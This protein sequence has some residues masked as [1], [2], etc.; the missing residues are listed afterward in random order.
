[1]K[2]FENIKLYYPERGIRFYQDKK[3]PFL[4]I[5]FSENS[6][7]LDDYHSL[8]MRRVD[9]RYVIV[10]I[11]KVPYSR[12]TPSEIKRYKDLKLIPLQ[13]NMKPPSGQNIIFDISGYLHMIDEKF[14]PKT[15]RQRAGMLIK[16]II[17]KSFM[18][19]PDNYR[20]VLLY[21]VDTGKPFNSF[22]DRKGYT[23]I[24]D[25][26][27]N[28]YLPYNNLI[29]CSIFNNNPFY[30][31]LVKDNNYNLQRT[32][33]YVRDIKKVPEG[34]DLEKEIKTVGDEIVKDVD[35]EKGK[36]NVKD[37]LSD[38]IEL[39]PEEMEDFKKLD[40]KDKKRFIIK[41]VLYKVSGNLKKS[42]EMA[43]KIPEKS[44]NSAL[45]VIEDKY[46][47][48]IIPKQ[49][50]KNLSRDN[51]TSSLPIGKMVQEKTPEHLFVKRKLDFD[52][53]LKKDLIE[54]F[55]LLEKKEIPLFLE[56]LEIRDKKVSFGEIEKTDRSEIIAILKDEN[57]KKHRVKMD[58][59]KIDL[60]TGTFFLNGRKNC[61][62]NQIVLCPISFPKPHDSKFHSSYSSFHVYS[63]KLKNY[64]FLEIYIGSFRIPL[65][66]F[67][68][69]GFGFEETLRKFNIDYQF[70]DK[71]PK[72]ETYFIKM[73]DKYILF[74]NVDN[75]VKKELIISFIKSGIEKLNI[76]KEFGT[77]EYF[78]DV[79]IKMS[80]RVD[81]TYIISTN[82]ENIVDPIAKQVLINQ[83]LP[84]E[85]FDIIKYMSEKTIIGFYQ[86]R[87]DIS[88][89]RIRNS[90]IIV[91][92][93]QKQLLAKYTE[94][95]EQYLSGNE[96]A[97]FDV[98]QKDVFSQ[99]INSPVVVSM[100]YANPA[101]EMAVITRIT[102]VGKFLGGISDRMAVQVGARNVHESYYGN[103]DPLDTPEGQNIGIVQ[104]LSVNALLTSSRGMF[105]TKSIAEDEKSGI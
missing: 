89:Q 82:I 36:D 22:F 51:I 27:E 26:R 21:S 65:S 104:Q 83:E 35:I 13:S 41:S 19:F 20:K 29:I 59:P 92:L 12:L 37:A 94:Y 34:E 85:L 81:S 25:M 100:E 3:S 31:L 9:D 2:R 64:S 6:S 16:N 101:E 78:N 17:R 39:N 42:E 95:K 50:S 60:E 66:I 53:N 47:D 87:N 49:K 68:F 69:Y 11:T 28:E 56:S 93:V 91:H 4:I 70:L 45:K 52:V 103:I 40:D 96:D 14:K 48:Q 73:G 88:N 1:M 102:P 98:P 55:K 8:N 24:S 63:K 72:D 97:K 10:P 105:K 57:G 61:L 71:K 67:L 32:M 74:L 30:R 54:A 44:L 5:Y 79:I 58:I 15:Y 38:M 62:I 90:E 86:E 46:V 84:Y 76:K 75:D 23:I 80:G 18:M 33:K 43:N 7:F 77:R 99:F